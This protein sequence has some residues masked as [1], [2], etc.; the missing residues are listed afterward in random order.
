MPTSTSYNAKKRRYRRRR[1]RR[2]RPN[3]YT[4]A[5]Q[6][7]RVRREVSSLPETKLHTMPLNLVGIGTAPYLFCMTDIVEGDSEGQRTGIQVTPTKFQ[8]Y[9]QAVAESGDDNWHRVIIFR[10]FDDVTPAVTDI[11]PDTTAGSF[12]GWSNL[13][14]P[15]NWITKPKFQILADQRFCTAIGTT[16]EKN[17]MFFDKSFRKTSKIRYKGSAAAAEWGSIYALVVNDSGVVP[18]P[19]YQGF[20]RLLYKDA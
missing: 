9:L 19:V 5:K 4:L 10:W 7:R 20:S 17:S 11:L 16:T 8:F 13:N 6:V 14:I 12:A 18:H 1:G 15:V 3:I 2:Y